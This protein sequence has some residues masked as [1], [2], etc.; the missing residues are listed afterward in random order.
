MRGGSFVLP[1]PAA[2]PSR[3]RTFGGV[4]PVSNAPAY[5]AALG[6]YTTTQFTTVA[7]GKPNLADIIPAT[8]VSASGTSNYG[9]NFNILAGFSGAAAD[10]VNARLDGC[11]AGHTDGAINLWWRA[12]FGG[13]TMPTGFSA[14]AYTDPANMVVE[15]DPQSNGVPN[16]T[17]S[18]AS[19][20][21][22]PVTRRAH[23]YAGAHWVSGAMPTKNWA[24]NLD[25]ASFVQG[26]DTT[27]AADNAACSFYGGDAVR[28]ALILNHAGKGWFHRL[29]ANTKST[30][31]NWNGTT[32][33]DGNP[34]A[35]Y[36]TTRGRAVIICPSQMYLVTPN[37]SAETIT[38]STL[39]PTGATSAITARGTCILYDPVADVFWILPLGDGVSTMSTIY[40]MNPTTWAITAHTVT[41]ATTGFTPSGASSGLFNRAVLMASWRA[42]C[43]VTD[44]NGGMYVTKLPATT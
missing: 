22:D 39:T 11:G 25:D 29:D 14:L 43:F 23:R 31:I 33:S 7:N 13:T 4:P 41:G 28:K 17:H 30:D 26:P 24:M 32:G 42:I 9:Q 35:A 34:V 36:D 20:F 1:R 21:R 3:G 5:I 16:A 18:Y 40:S 19:M 8:W 15:T 2:L 6:D 37:W 12:D 44:I 27:Y 10:N 38:E